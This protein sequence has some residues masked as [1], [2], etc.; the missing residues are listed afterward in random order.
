MNYLSWTSPSLPLSPPDK[1]DVHVWKFDLEIDQNIYSRLKILL[2]ED[3]CTRALSYNFERDRKNFTISRGLLR[4]ILGMYLRC[5][6]KELQF[7]YG[8]YGKPALAS[9]HATSLSFNLSHT[10]NLMLFVCS[11]ERNVGIDVEW[12]HDLPDWRGIAK[13][14]FSSREL[15]DLEKIPA[16]QQLQAFF[17]CWTRKEAYIKAIGGGLSIPLKHFDV[18][19]APNEPARLL[20]NI[21]DTDRYW[22]MREINVISGYA[23]ALIA[24]G[25]YIDVLKLTSPIQHLLDSAGAY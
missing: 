24:E 14:L 11:L 7:Q 9:S 5:H 10:N 20:R 3:E 1:T 16:E 2:T 4:T 23:A 22:S 19:L 8:E 17:N 13:K 18:S 21:G 6:P 15:E 12:V 25:K